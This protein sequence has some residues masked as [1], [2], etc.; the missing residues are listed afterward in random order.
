MF[1]VQDSFNISLIPRASRRS[2]H[3][4]CVGSHSFLS[5]T[6]NPISSFPNLNKISLKQEL[7]RAVSSGNLNVSVLGFALPGERRLGCGLK[8]RSLLWR[9]CTH[10]ELGLLGLALS[11]VWVLGCKI[12]T[13][14]VGF[15]VVEMLQSWIIDL[16]LWISTWCGIWVDLVIATCG[17]LLSMLFVLKCGLNVV[18]LL[19]ELVWSSMESSSRC[20]FRGVGSFDE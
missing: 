19:I 16:E 2:N 12:Y 1:L 8:L 13:V 3:S 18:L 6:R 15:G 10:P 7:I 20:W 4:N 5:I 17:G 9:S 11:C 14:G